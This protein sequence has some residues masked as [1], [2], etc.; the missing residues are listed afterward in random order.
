MKH[1]SYLAR[2]DIAQ[3]ISFSDDHFNTIVSNTSLKHIEKIDAALR[4]IA[5]VLKSGGK[6]YATF[7]SHYAYHWWPCGHDAL[8][9]YLTFQPIYNYFHLQEWEDRMGIV[10][11]LVVRH[12]YYFSKIAS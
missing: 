2:S 5:G 1:Y 8:D 6:L 7:A 12:L 3:G 4:E 11:L 9:R 10:G